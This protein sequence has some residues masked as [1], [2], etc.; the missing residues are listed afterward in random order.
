VLIS[1]LYR[2]TES[3][4]PAY[5]KAKPVIISGEKAKADCAANEEVLLSSYPA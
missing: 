1:T 3:E 2:T 5:S 4:A